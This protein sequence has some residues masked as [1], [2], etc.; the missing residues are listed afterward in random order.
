MLSKRRSPYGRYGRDPY[1]S[2]Y[3]ARQTGVR[4]PVHQD[5]RLPA[6]AL[7]QGVAVDGAAR[8]YPLEVLREQPVRNDT[9]GGLPIVVVFQAASRTGVVFERRVGG[10]VLTFQEVRAPQRAEPEPPEQEPDRERRGVLTE[11]LTR[12]R[13]PEPTRAAHDVQVIQDEETGTAWAIPSG[14]ALTG[15]SA[16]E[17]LRQLPAT[18]AFWFGWKDH[19][20]ETTIFGEHLAGG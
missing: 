5:P 3:H 2:Y 10:D 19:Y 17:Q 4:R 18:L 16:A 11:W 9:L 6:K 14:G 1:Q 12:L 15:E 8:A 7:V 13:R 20:P